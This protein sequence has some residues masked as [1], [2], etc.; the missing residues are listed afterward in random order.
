MGALLHIL[1]ADHA[2]LNGEPIMDDPQLPNERAEMLAQI[3]NLSR[4]AAEL[5]ADLDVLT[6]KHAMPMSGCEITEITV[7]EARLLIEYE[8]TPA[9]ART[10]DAP[11]FSAAVSPIRAFVNGCWIKI[12][13]LCDALDLDRLAQRIEDGRAE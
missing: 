9:Q 2:R 12:D 1:A 11:G 13:D 10:W 6:G 7:E 8:Y 5:Q 4:L 3:D